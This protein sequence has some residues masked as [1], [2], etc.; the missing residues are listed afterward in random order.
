M[1]VIKAFLLFILGAI[2]FVAIIIGVLFIL[3][4]SP[5]KVVDTTWTQGDFD[6]YVE[7]G[8]IVFDD[9]HASAEDFFAG[10]IKGSGEVSVDA[11]V[12]DEELSAIA[13]KAL[14]ENSVMTDISINC[15]GDEKI[16]MS[17]VIG[18][19]TP[20]ISMFPQLEQFEFAF[21]LLENKP[22]YMDATLFYDESTGLFDGTTKELYVGKIKI[23]LKQANDNLKPGGTVLN[24]S[25]KSLNGFSVNEFTV[26]DKGFNFDG[27]IPEKIESAGSFEDLSNAIND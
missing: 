21:K 1:K 11:V 16:E 8:G 17:C 3:I 5:A 9:S 26:S 27:T 18:D 4:S 19:L 10:N 12:T 20:L 7:K 2:L 6:S 22:I 13:N 14:N 24:D 25:I 23:P 15:Y